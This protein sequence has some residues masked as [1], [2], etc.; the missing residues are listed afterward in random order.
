MYDHSYFVYEQLEEEVIWMELQVLF[1]EIFDKD[2]NLVQHMFL[3]CRLT[4]K[5]V[6]PSG[7]WIR[8]LQ[9]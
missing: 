9:H 7:D 4:Q 2:S 3:L 6:I 5:F 8:N 1:S